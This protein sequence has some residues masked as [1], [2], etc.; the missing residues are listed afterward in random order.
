MA[1]MKTVQE[2]AKMD[3]TPMIDCVFL[4]MIFFVL[5]IDL[6]QQDLEDLILPKAVFIEPDDDTP[7]VRPIANILQS[8]DIFHHGTKYYDVES[9]EDYSGMEKLLREWRKE[10][11]L[12]MLPRDGRGTPV[13]A[14][15]PLIPDN[16]VLIRA[17]KWTEW[18]RIGTFTTQC[19]QPY[20]AFWKLELAM[21][22]EDKERKMLSAATGRQP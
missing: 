15:N 8:G 13:S 14:T 11:D 22:E 5:V 12:T 10:L 21:S 19:S 7:D 4:L 17:D 6:S 1:N 2:D 16:P 20:A 9:G 3:M 18:H